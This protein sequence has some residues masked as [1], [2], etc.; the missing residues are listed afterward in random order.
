MDNI[1]IMIKNI[2]IVN[3]FAYINGGA[4]KVAI[5]SAI[6]LSQKG[7]R[8]IFFTS[9][10]PIC[11]ELEQSEIEVVCTHQHDIF[12]DP[13]RLR[14]IRQGLW[15]NKSK[16]KLQQIIE[17][18]SPTETVI[19]IHGWIKALSVSIFDTIKRSN[20]PVF[21]T[22][23]DFFLCCPNGGLYDYKRQ[24]IC[25]R[26]PMGLS[27]MTCNCDVRNYSQKIYR[28]IRQCICKYT[29]RKIRSNIYYI[30]ISDTTERIFKRE[31]GNHFKIIR[32][33]NPIDSPLS[34]VFEE[35]ARDS[36]LFM[37]RLS[38]EKGLDLFCEAITQLGLKGIVL[39]TGELYETYKEK[40]PNIEFAGWVRGEQKIPYLKQ[41]K[42]LIFPSKWYEGAPLTTIEIMTYG[43][44]CITSNECAASELI[45]EGINGFIFQTGKLESL[46]NAIL[47]MEK[48]NLLSR[49]K[50]IQSSIDMNLFGE[51]R[52]IEKLIS[53]YETANSASRK[54]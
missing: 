1:E 49:R 42:C 51:E 47:K 22:L 7:F 31:Y 27:C 38:S 32:I 13:N 10:E 50:Q 45:K 35:N 17:G 46:K 29:M 24:Q 39:G 20:I 54:T 19:H 2:I 25:H 6:G 11:K 8:V 34:V 23:H 16:K 9:V 37:A 36:Y 14:A 5:M 21:Y 53:A 18:L 41:S 30:S 33:N 48:S 40:Y 3:D 28:V 4:A 44:P 43:I 12:S 52:H 26:K 15:N